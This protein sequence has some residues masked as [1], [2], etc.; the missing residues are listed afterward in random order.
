MDLLRGAMSQQFR[1]IDGAVEGKPVA[2]QPE[3]V[4]GCMPAAV[5]WI[6]SS[7]STPISIRSGITGTQE[8]QEW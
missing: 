3:E 2:E 8:P 6:G 5:T 4:L 7:T 1:L